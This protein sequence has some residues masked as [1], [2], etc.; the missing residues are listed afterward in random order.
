MELPEPT[1]NERAQAQLEAALNGGGGREDGLI[2]LFRL[3]RDHDA[4]D[5]LE[6]AFPEDGRRHAALTELR[7]AVPQRVSELLAR[8]GGLPKCGGDLI[9]PFDRLGEMMDRYRDGFERRGLEYAVWGH[10][11]D[12]NL[13][14]NA[15]PRDEAE[16][17]PAVEALLEFGREATRLGGC[18]LSEHGVGRSP[19]KQRMLREFLGPDAVDQMRRIKRALDPQARFAPGVLFPA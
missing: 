6:L 15:L 14:P 5:A 2:R 1:D 3:L 8:R 18:P 16:L 19:I 12:G 17:A 4:L 11:G 10:L 9:V 7:E 13:H